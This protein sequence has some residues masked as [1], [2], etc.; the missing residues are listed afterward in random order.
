VTRFQAVGVLLVV[1]G[2]VY[3]LLYAGWLRSPRR[4]ASAAI[5]A[6]RRRTEERSQEA[7]VLHDERAIQVVAQGT[8][9]STTTAASRL[10]RVTVEGLGNLSRATLTVNRGDADQ[11]VRIERR[12]ESTVVVPAG[13]LLAVRRDRG[14][15]GKFVGSN[16]LLV[17]TWR[18]PEGDIYETG[19]L[20]RY[21]ADVDKVESALWWHATTGPTDST[22]ASEPA[23][24]TEP[25]EPPAI[26]GKPSA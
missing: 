13:R 12:G 15:V 10:E 18:A 19:F 5:A 11:L 6:E 14:M 20:P 17:L 21:K 25:T 24:P 9:V 2:L 1:L 26:E 23:E 7:P 3:A 8:Y 22:D 16:R 4:H